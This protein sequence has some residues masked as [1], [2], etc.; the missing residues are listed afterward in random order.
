MGD[1]LTRWHDIPE[2]LNLGCGEDIRDGW[3]NVDAVPLDGVDQVI[4]LNDS[5]WH[6]PADH[7]EFVL[8][9]HVFEH[10]DDIDT[11][12]REVERILA[13]GGRLEVRMPIGMNYLSDDTHQHH[14]AWRTPVNKLQN[15]W[16]PDFDLRIVD[17]DVDIHGFGGGKLKLLQ[18]AKFRLF[19]WLFGPGNWAWRPPG[20]TLGPYGGE[21]TVVF[22]KYE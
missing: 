12:L 16:E 18:G 21:F 22:E 15:H 2:R 1:K 10:L 7:F 19:Q 13:V 9:K 6:L 3:Y 8:A 5:Q 17:R 4:D 20:P 14:W 11:A